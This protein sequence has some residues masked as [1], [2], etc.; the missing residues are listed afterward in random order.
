[1]AQRG[2][3]PEPKRH[4]A[5]TVTRTRRD[6]TTA[7]HETTPKVATAVATEAE[8]IIQLLPPASLC[9]VAKGE[10]DLNDLARCHLA[11]R[12]LDQRGRWVGFAE[13]LRLYEASSLLR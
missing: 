4:R 6:G 13:A 2:T 7:N 10:L 9:A 5:E 1:V 8:E 3:A 12:G 11:A